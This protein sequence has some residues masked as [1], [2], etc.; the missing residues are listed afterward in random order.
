MYDYAKA[1]LT[2]TPQPVDG[3]EWLVVVVLQARFSVMN[4][5]LAIKLRLLVDWRRLLG[6]G[7]SNRHY[8]GCR[9]RSG[10]THENSDQGGVVVGCAGSGIDTYTDEAAEQDI[11]KR[12]GFGA[13][14]DGCKAWRKRILF[15]ADP[16]VFVATLDHG[17]A[18]GRDK[19]RSLIVAELAVGTG[20]AAC[21]G[22]RFH[23]NALILAIDDRRAAYALGCSNDE[24]EKFELHG[25]GMGEEKP[26]LVQNF[27]W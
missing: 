24:C 9:N 25:D 20:D 12:H 17:R 2:S 7:R 3:G 15:A 21:L 16:E 10:L 6:R 27:C 5:V 26:A 22:A 14:F 23:G 19:P 4:A 18:W 13:G 8:C 11:A 1:I